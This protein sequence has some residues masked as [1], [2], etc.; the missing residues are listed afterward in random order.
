MYPDEHVMPA[1][2]TA[3]KTSYG[4]PPPAPGSSIAIVGAGIVGTCC[5][6]E[7][8]DHGYA[9]TLFDRGSPG[10]EGASRA[11]AGQIIPSIIQPV[12]YPGIVRDVPGLLLDRHGPLS[13]APSYL[14]R[15]LPWLWRFVLASRRRDHD[16]GVRQLAE[17]NAGALEATR[18]LYRRA[19]LLPWLNDTGALHLHETPA[20]LA[21]ARES[22]KLKAAHGYAHAL[23]DPGELRDIEPD[24]ASA[25]AGA[26]LEPGVAHVSDPLRIVEGLYRYAVDRGAAFERRD[27]R[28]AGVGPEGITLA[29][30]DGMRETFDGLVIAAGAWSRQL[31]KQIGDDAPLESERG[32]NL[33]IPRPGV[34]IRHCLVFADRGFV[35]TPLQPGLR[36]GGC[37]ELAGLARPPDPRRIQRIMEIAKTLIPALDDRDGNTWMGHRPALPDSVP[38]IRQSP[39]DAR[40]TYAFGHG[41]LGLTQA[42][43]TA[44]RVL[45]LM[46]GP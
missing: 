35:A 42:P 21:R 20:S 32:Y 22:W 12:A 39:V 33:T 13:I 41:H 18:D 5:A 25:F 27:V 6:A 36:I 15:L 11:N 45:G 19:G 40:V 23:I 24:L 14:P 28:I 16:R 37:V 44:R 31:L 4:A 7:L 46:A 30:A 2:D 3:H 38:V 9:V 1:T 17:L 26:V 34:D 43:V 8:S 29:A 10:W